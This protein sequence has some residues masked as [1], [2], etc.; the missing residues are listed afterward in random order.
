MSRVEVLSGPERRRRWSTEQKQSIVGR[1]LR[2][3]LRSARLP[4]AW[5]WCPDRFIAGGAICGRDEVKFI[6][7]AGARRGGGE[8]HRDDGPTQGKSL[9]CRA[10]R[11]PC[12]SL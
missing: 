11:P 9:R 12:R 2:R 10:A 3:A 1:L 4:G 5:M 8:S 6:S 7:P